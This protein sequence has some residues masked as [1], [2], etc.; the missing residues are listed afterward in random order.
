[1][2]EDAKCAEKSDF[3][4]LTEQQT[5]NSAGWG[6]NEATKDTGIHCQDQNKK[7]IALDLVQ[8]IAHRIG[9]DG[10]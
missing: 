10:G 8:N 2:V 1:M 5:R 3:L 6:S 9:Q 4:I 7:T